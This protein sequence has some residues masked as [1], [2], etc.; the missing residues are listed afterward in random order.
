MLERTAGV[1]RRI[2]VDALDLAGELLFE[3]FQGKQVVAEDQAIVEQ[4]AVGDP[5][6]RMVG[7]LLVLQQDARLQLRPV[8]LPD[9][10]Q[11]E[12]WLGH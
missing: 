9:P 6:H 3:G 11:F 7:P 1:V 8:L 10:C 5:V 2:D 4:V 12:L